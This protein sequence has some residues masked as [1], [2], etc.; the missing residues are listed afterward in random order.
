MSSTVKEALLA[1]NCRKCP[2]FTGKLKVPELGQPITTC[3]IVPPIIH[4]MNMN[5]DKQP[6]TP[7]GPLTNSLRTFQAAI[8][9]VTTWRIVPPVIRHL[10]KQLII[11]NGP[12]AA[13]LR[14]F[15]IVVEG[16][17]P[18]FA[19]IGPHERNCK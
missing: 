6:T 9:R 14:T 18:E 15:Q 11:P 10:T 12:V 13:D 1:D 17:R 7:D 8:E 16:A 4:G 2:Q 5:T 19:G 3:R